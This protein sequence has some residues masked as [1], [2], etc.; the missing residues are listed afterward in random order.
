MRLEWI[1]EQ[2]FRPLAFHRR[3]EKLSRNKEGNEKCDRRTFENDGI[4]WYPDVSKSPRRTRFLISFEKYPA[5]LIGENTDLRMPEILDRV[6][7]KLPHVCLLR[8]GEIRVFVEMRILLESKTLF[9]LEAAEV[10]K[11]FF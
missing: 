5:R 8:C 6:G 3:L 4:L 10:P 1:L 2:H 9:T 7:S 11:N